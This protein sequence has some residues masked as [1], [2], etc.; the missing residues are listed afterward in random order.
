MGNSAFK[1]CTS[2]SSIT[3]PNSVTSLGSG[4]LSGCPNLTSIT[5]PFV[6]NSSTSTGN[7]AKFGFIFGASLYLS[8]FFCF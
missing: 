5:I 2:L 6:G 7:D 1:G 3:I 8:S 4:L